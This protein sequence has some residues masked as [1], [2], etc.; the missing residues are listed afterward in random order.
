MLG[1]AA[2][3]MCCD[4]PAAHLA[5]QLPG[6]THGAG[7]T[8]LAGLALLGV[9]GAL[10]GTGRAR[11]PTRELTCCPVCGEPAPGCVHTDWQEAAAAALSGR[12]PGQLL[13]S[14]AAGPSMAELAWSQRGADGRDQIALSGALLT[15]ELAAQRH[16]L[17][18][19][20]GHVALG[21]TE[22]AARRGPWAEPGVAIWAVLTVPQLRSSGRCLLGSAHLLAVAAVLLTLSS[23]TRAGVGALLSGWLLLTAQVAWRQRRWELRMERAAEVFAYRAARAQ[24][25]S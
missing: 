16:V 2:L 10:A 7:W 13:V 5:A 18:H 22:V 24:E 25:R 8:F 1:R 9:W 15:L 3:T 14:W 4:R 23:V 12:G 19:E 11:S 20:C 6:A 21:H 17:A